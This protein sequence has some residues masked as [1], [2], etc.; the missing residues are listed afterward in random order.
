[1][2]V[3]YY[4]RSI[5]IITTLQRQITNHRQYLCEHS[6]LSQSSNE[7]RKG[8]LIESTK[9]ICED[10][11][12]KTGDGF[13]NLFSKGSYMHLLKKRIKTKED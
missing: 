11:Q 5:Y 2:Y 7:V 6:E 9:T 1:M 3:L 8:C 12:Y 10:H 13:V 4:K